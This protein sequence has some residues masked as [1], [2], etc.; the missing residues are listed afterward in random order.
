[1]RARVLESFFSLVQGLTLGDVS[2]GVYRTQGQSDLVLETP[3]A[4]EA[5]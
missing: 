3:G 2:G 5:D 4:S 1:M